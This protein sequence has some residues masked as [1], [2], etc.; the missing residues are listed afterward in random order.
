MYFKL[1]S[2]L[3]TI[4]IHNHLWG[5][6]DGSFAFDP[7]EAD[8]LLQAADRIG[9]VKIGVSNPDVGKPPVSKSDVAKRNDCI[10]QA[11]QYLSVGTLTTIPLG[12][13]ENI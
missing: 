7:N 10:I 11:M 1:P 8:M 12:S 9:V 4:D 3:D 13:P 6:Q 2:E 5:R